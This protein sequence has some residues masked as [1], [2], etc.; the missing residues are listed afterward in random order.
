LVG[1]LLGQKDYAAVGHAE[2]TSMVRVRIATAVEK[3]DTKGSY[4][5][6]K[7]LGE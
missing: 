5:S 6:L 3:E 7:D 2:L 1:F 4:R